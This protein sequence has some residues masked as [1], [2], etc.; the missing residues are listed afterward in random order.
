MQA[1]GWQGGSIRL[2]WRKSTGGY[3]LR[4]HDEF[5]D[6]LPWAPGDETPPY[7]CPIEGLRGPTIEFELTTAESGSAIAQLVNM[8]DSDEDVLGFTNAWGQLDRGGN[9]KQALLNFRDQ[10]RRVCSSRSKF[11]EIEKIMGD[12]TLGQAA[13]RFGRRAKGRGP[14][15]LLW[16]VNSL[17]DF[18]WLGLAEDLGGIGGSTL[19]KCSD[20]GKWFQKRGL[21]GPAPEHCS[22][23]CR[24]RAYRLGKKMGVRLKIAF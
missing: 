19:I 12:Q 10:L 15:D 18:C 8:T 13:I 5:Y 24:Q 20:C 9:S 23:A 11:R 17:R 16:Y 7:I 21:K 3:Q 2:Q 1:K 6:E 14:I 4:D 22:N